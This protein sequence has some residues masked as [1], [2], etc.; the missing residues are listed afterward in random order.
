[1]RSSPT[2]NMSTTAMSPTIDSWM[3][4]CTSEGCHR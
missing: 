2:E 3:T 1:V 4:F